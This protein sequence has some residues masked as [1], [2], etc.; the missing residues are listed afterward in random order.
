MASQ[1]PLPGVRGTEGLSSARY[2]PISVPHRRPTGNVMSLSGFGTEV[3][4][5]V[6]GMGTGQRNCHEQAGRQ[7]AG[8]GPW[9]QSHTKLPGSTSIRQWLLTNKSTGVLT[10]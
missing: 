9:H 8:I 7:G 2:L 1:Q 5:K 4:K 3:A 6:L 10:F